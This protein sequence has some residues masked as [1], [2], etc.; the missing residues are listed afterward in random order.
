MN[1][2]PTAV[3]SGASLG[4]FRSGLYA[5]R[6]I[7]ALTTAKSGIV[8]ASV[9]SRPRM[10]MSTAVFSSR[11]KTEMIIVLATRPDRAKTSPWAKL[12]SW[13]MP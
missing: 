10:I 8:T 9:P 7:V 13:R 1:D 3:I 6:S 4:A 12:M 11:P 5:M 2:T